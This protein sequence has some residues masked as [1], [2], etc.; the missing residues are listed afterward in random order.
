M[1]ARGPKPSDDKRVL[2]SFR[3][4]KENDDIIQGIMELEN[5]DKSTCLREL[6]DIGIHYY[7]SECLK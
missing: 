2:V 1:G 3:I 4:S 6:L 7:T 5:T